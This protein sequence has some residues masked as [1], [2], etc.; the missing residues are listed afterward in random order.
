M[1]TDSEIWTEEERSGLWLYG[2]AARLFGALATSGSLYKV[3]TSLPLNPIEIFA[4]AASFTIGTFVTLKPSGDAIE[5]SKRPD[6]D[7]Q[8]YRENLN[9]N[10]PEIAVA[11]SI[12][13]T[14][15]MLCAGLDNDQARW[16]Q[17]IDKVLLESPEID[18]ETIVLA[19][20]RRIERAKDKCVEGEPTALVWH[21][22]KFHHVDCTPKP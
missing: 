21:D 13:G 15:F 19:Y 20:D 2:C 6:W 5:A 16:K 8:K 18:R 3:A 10:T 7:V 11:C 12:L 22:G 4:C 14:A 9:R 17:S 1:H